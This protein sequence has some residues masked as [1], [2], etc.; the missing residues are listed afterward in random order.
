MY[1]F[2]KQGLALGKITESAGKLP[3]QHLESITHQSTPQT[4]PNQSGQPLVRK[5]T[6]GK[7]ETSQNSK[8]LHNDL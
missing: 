3:T 8:R 1:G 5:L 2:Q 4:I 6:F 7:N